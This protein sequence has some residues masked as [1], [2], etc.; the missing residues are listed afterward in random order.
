MIRL[1]NNIIGLSSE[2]EQTFVESANDPAHDPSFE[3][4]QLSCDL[5]R[6]TAIVALLT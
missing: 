6:I 2:T 1:G 4:L 3:L 5:R